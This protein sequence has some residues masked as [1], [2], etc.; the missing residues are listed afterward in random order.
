VKSSTKKTFFTKGYCVSWKEKLTKHEEWQPL[1]RRVANELPNCP[2]CRKRADWQ[3][4]KKYGWTTRGYRIICALCG[5]EWEYIISKLT[6]KDLLLGNEMWDIESTMPH[7]YHVARL[8]NDESIWI[9]RKVG[10]NPA[11][12][13]KTFLDKKVTFST[14]KQTANFQILQHFCGKCGSALVENEKFCPKCGTARD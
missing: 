7:S 14:W 1:L 12:N 5:A 11:K 3:V 6:T 8:T 10:S 4:H 13:T 2:M 9:L